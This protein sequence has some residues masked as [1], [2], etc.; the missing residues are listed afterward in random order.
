MLGFV[1]ITVYEVTQMEEIGSS[2]SDLSPMSILINSIEMKQKEVFLGC[3]G[4]S[5]SE[6]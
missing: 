2:F 4:N 3:S 5:L 1:E 6:R